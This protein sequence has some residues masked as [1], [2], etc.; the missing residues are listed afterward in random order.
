MVPLS[1]KNS[2]PS[3]KKCSPWQSPSTMDSF[4]TLGY[5]SLSSSGT[6]LLDRP[7]QDG[8]QLM[9][10]KVPAFEKTFLYSFLSAERAQL[11]KQVI[12][13]SFLVGRRAHPSQSH[14]QWIVLL[15]WVFQFFCQVEHVH[16]VYHCKMED[17]WRT[18]MFPL[19]EKTN[20]LVAE[21]RRS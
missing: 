1:A 11:Q 12:L 8:R 16:L 10:W 5:S 17:N 7:L 14:Q 15:P 21:C 4:T 6:Y 13:N 19:L 2:L 3:S 9:N 18:E 20:V